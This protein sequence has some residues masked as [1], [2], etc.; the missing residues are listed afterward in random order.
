MLMSPTP[1]SFNMLMN[2][3][4]SERSM[5]R[6]SCGS[7]PKPYSYGVTESKGSGDPRPET[8]AV[9]AGGV[10]SERQCIEGA[11]ADTDHQTGRLGTDPLYDLSAES[12][13]A[14]Q[15]CLR[16][17]SGGVCVRSTVRARDIRD[18]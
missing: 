16:T 8:L 12:R 5:L 11:D 10:R 3:K 9:G 18:N 7:S 2:A 6:G 1:S 14:R 17:C 15:A 4:V 13:S